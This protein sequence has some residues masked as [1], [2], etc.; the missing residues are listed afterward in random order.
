M[1]E[2]GVPMSCNFNYQ[3]MEFVSQGRLGQ[4]GL[5]P[6]WCSQVLSGVY[7]YFTDRTADGKERSRTEKEK[8]EYVCPHEMDFNGKVDNFLILLQQFFSRQLAAAVKHAV[9]LLKVWR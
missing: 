7:R 5:S 1:R 9:E 3:M 8:I 6:W 4:Y 2:K